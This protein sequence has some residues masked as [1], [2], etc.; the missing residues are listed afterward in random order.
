[1]FVTAVVQF[2]NCF[3]LFYSNSNQMVYFLLQHKC[4][5]K[6][7]ETLMNTYTNIK[8]VKKV[9]SIVKKLASV[10]VDCE[11]IGR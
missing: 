9:A 11:N 1:M 3:S 5:I 4:C 10:F 6:I 2:K 7:Q 8:L